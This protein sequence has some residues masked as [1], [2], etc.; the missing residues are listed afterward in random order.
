MPLYSETPGVDMFN[1]L[2]IKGPQGLW[3]GQQG[4]AGNDFSLTQVD[5]DLHLYRD[6]TTGAFS[7]LRT[8]SQAANAAPI[9][10][11]WGQGSIIWNTHP[12]PGGNVGWICTTSGTPGIW[13][14][15]GLI[16]L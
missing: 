9:T 8:G 12:I 11:T 15:F 7:M 6:E 13:N 5:P 10:G 4:I 3:L 1:S 16:S 2:T 14:P